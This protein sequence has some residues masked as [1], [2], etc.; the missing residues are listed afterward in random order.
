[1]NTP[2]NTKPIDASLDGL[3]LQWVK[4]NP[5][6]AFE[7]LCEMQAQRQAPIK[8]VITIESAS[9]VRVQGTHPVDVSV[10]DAELEGADDGDI[11]TFTDENGSSQFYAYA[12]GVGQVDPE[13]V[14]E[15]E[16]IL[17]QS[18]LADT[19]HEQAKYP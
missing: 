3:S 2:F 7:R 14:Q 13:M 9:V 15:V 18:A 5:D 17:A 1:M 8:L 4:D 16:Q 19:S 11:H 12:V 6:Q 10:L